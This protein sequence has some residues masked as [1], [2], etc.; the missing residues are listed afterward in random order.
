VPKP[1]A[2]APNVAVILLDDVGFG[3]VST[4][5]GPVTTPELEKLAAKGL[6]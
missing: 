6:R 4:F 2:G 3:Q 1:P 5:G